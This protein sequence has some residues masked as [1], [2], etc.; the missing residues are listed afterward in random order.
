MLGDAELRELVQLG[1][2]FDQIQ[3][4]V[5]RRT[6]RRSTVASLSAALSRATL[7]QTTGHRYFDCIPWRVRPEHA[8]CEPAPLLRLLGRHRSGFPLP[9]AH[10]VR[11]E[12]WLQQLATLGLV[13]AYNP[14]WPEG[15]RYI[16][17]EHRNGPNPDLPIAVR[18]PEAP[19]CNLRP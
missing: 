7:V 1:W 8:G 16:D 3:H 14:Q 11:L 9:P 4:E 2:T 15:F 17:E 10:I 18:P 12:L 5:E 19:P 6:G 13:V